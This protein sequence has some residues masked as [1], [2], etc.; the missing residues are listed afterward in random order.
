M[1][2]LKSISLLITVLALTSCGGSKRFQKNPIDEMVRDMPTGQVFSIILNDMDVQGNFSDTYFHQYKVIEN[3]ADGNPT[4]RLTDWKKVPEGFFQMHIN[5]MGMEIA[6]RGEDGQLK[7]TVNPPGYSN[8]VG[9]PKY[10]QWKQRDGYSFWE[11]YG[12]YAFM[13][14]MFNMM[15]YP[16]RRSYYYDWRNNYYGTGRVYYGPTYGSGRYYGT[17]SS[18]TRTTRP[19]STWNSKPNTFR[20]RVANR[21]SRSSSRYSSSSSSRSRGGGIGK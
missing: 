18:Y 5:N 4:E 9:N 15:A 6:S 12:Q 1:K 21:T 10:G 7:K 2:L 3:D 16:V 11:F 13:S 20:Q 14:S 17:S 19:N 8:Y